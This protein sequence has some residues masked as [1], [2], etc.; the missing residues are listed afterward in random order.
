[1]VNHS[2]RNATLPALIAAL[3]LGMV[4]TPALTEKDK[5]PVGNP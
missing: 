4:A 3:L 2:S 5:V 1:M